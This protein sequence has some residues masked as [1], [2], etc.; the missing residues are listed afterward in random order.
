MMGS[1]RWVS[2]IS[3][4]V[5]SKAK[6]RES[7]NVV[8]KDRDDDRDQPPFGLGATP[9]NVVARPSRM[10]KTTMFPAPYCSYIHKIERP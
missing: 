5:A 3:V 7:I 1:F 10:N 4:W 2:A 9:A 6:L 8:I